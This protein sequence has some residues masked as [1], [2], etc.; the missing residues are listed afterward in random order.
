MVNE[1]GGPRQR[2]EPTPEQLIE[3]FTTQDNSA[4]QVFHPRPQSFEELAQLDPQTANAIMCAANLPYLL[5]SGYVIPP[6]AFL[7]GG[8]GAAVLAAENDG[9]HSVYRTHHDVDFLVLEDMLPAH[10]Y[11][12]SPFGGI[13]QIAKNIYRSKVSSTWGLPAS[14]FNKVGSLR[15]EVQVDLFAYHRKGNK[16]IFSGGSYDL[17]EFTLYDLFPEEEAHM[18][19]KICNLYGYDYYIRE[20]IVRKMKT[21][22]AKSRQKGQVDLAHIS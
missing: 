9:T 1:F 5:N 21:L 10:N 11:A 7:V 4:P 12:L 14:V 15:P 17:F 16:G 13:R 2:I 18:Q 22:D 3:A 6:T 20:D 8:V 19:L